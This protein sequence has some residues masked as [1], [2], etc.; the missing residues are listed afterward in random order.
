MNVFYKHHRD[1]IRFGYRCFDRILL[2]GLPAVSAARA[3]DR[4]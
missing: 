3:G 4:L 1:S 2:D